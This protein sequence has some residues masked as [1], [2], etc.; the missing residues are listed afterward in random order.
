MKKAASSAFTLIELLV[1][2]S[3]IGILAAFIV[4][5]VMGAQDKAKEAAVKAVAHTVQLAVEAYHLENSV[6]PLSSTISLRSLIDNYLT[7]GGYMVTIPKNPFTGTEYS[8]DDHA[9]QITYSYDDASNKYLI[10]AFKRNGATQ[11]LQLSNF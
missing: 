3:I 11:I 8:V 10:T 2:I 1:V 6:Y 4:P 5:N 9:G 7:A